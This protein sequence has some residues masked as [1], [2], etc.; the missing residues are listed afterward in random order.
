MVGHGGHSPETK[1]SR[2]TSVC[3]RPACCHV[4]CGAGRKSDPCLRCAGGARNTRA[5]R[6]WNM[7]GLRDHLCVP[8]LGR[9]KRSACLPWRAR[10]AGLCRKQIELVKTFADQASIAI[11]NVRL[12]EEVQAR[13]GELS[14]SLQQQT[15]TADVLKAISRSTFD[16]RPSRNPAGV[17]RPALRGRQGSHLRTRRR[18]LPVVVAND[19]NPPE[20]VEHATE[21]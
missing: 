1:R 11:E 14:E 17:G 2:S 3:P 16:L 12:F 19:L 15:A 13:T 9:T 7:A 5:G 8:V 18:R 6:A 4:A 20:F 10:R 21:Q